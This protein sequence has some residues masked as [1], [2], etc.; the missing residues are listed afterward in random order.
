MNQ[1]QFPETVNDSNVDSLLSET[2]RKMVPL[3]VIT[4]KSYGQVINMIDVP[5]VEH[6]ELHRLLENHQLWEHRYI[7]NTVRKY[8]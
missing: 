5:E 6:P 3:V 4:D 2:I 1:L 7:K 8:F